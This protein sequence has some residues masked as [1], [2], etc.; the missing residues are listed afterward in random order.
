MGCGSSAALP[1]AKPEISEKELDDSS[2]GNIA[3]AP[4]ASARRNSPTVNTQ[5]ELQAEEEP[6]SFT[7][8]DEDSKNDKRALQ[9]ASKA[10]PSASGS[11]RSIP[12][13]HLTDEEEDTIKDW[14]KNI[15]ME[16]PSPLDDPPQTA[17]PA[18]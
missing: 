10:G 4:V 6:P 18:V 2:T 9:T 8:T 5:E 16:Q 14:L 13:S 3:P 17:E 12:G 1:V 7:P 11:E 15:D